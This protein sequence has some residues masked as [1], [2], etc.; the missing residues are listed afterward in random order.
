MNLEMD[1]PIQAILI[2]AAI[3][4]VGFAFVIL[5]IENIW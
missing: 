3:A 4:L 5:V 2:G 1:N